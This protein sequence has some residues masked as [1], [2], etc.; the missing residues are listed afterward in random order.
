M[1]RPHKKGRSREKWWLQTVAGPVTVR[2]LL[3]VIGLAITMQYLDY[4][5]TLGQ[6]EGWFLDVALRWGPQSSGERQIITVEIDKTAYDKFFCSKSPLET[7]VVTSL[8]KQIATAADNASVIGVDILTESPVYADVVTAPWFND[9]KT[10]WAAD[11]QT[12]APTESATFLGWLAGR[13]DEWSFELPLVLGKTRNDD[14]PVKWGASVYV[15]DRDL[16]VRKLTREFHRTQRSADLK[17]W[18]REV[19]KAFRTNSDT[20]HEEVLVSYSTLPPLEYKV[21]DLFTCNGGGAQCCAGE[22]VPSGFWNEFKQELQRYRPIVLIGGTFDS[23]RDLD[24]PIGRQPGLIVD[25]YAVQAELSQTYVRD[26]H[27]WLK[28]VFD[29]PLGLATG[30]LVL[31]FAKRSMRRG[32]QISFLIAAV[33]IVVSV[34]LIHA[35]ILWFS[36]AGVAFGAMLEQLV[37]LY[38]ENP[39]AAD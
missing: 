23:S 24:T 29:I 35:G 15:H 32:M 39:K 22:P 1:R 37:E 28:F 6:W 11:A 5:G 30:W 36:F 34:F 13:N 21:S 17:V 16:G 25:A 9:A 14:D 12:S 27:P 33:I 3:V 19:A 8:V 2:N 7:T 4:R 10:V 31:R 20:T 38:I 26:F 18:A